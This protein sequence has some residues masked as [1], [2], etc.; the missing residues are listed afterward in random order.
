MTVPPA[1]TPACS[2]RSACTTRS[3]ADAS[4]SRALLL[5]SA[6]SLGLLSNS[7]PSTSAVTMNSKRPLPNAPLGQAKLMLRSTF[8]PPSSAPAL[9]T[10]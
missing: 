9:A 2:M 1:L 8:A 7:S 10:S 3:G 6:L 4:T 5:L